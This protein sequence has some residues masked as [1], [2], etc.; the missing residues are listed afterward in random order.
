MDTQRLCS[1]NNVYSWFLETGFC[2]FDGYRQIKAITIALC[3]YSCHSRLST[4]MSSKCVQINKCDIFASPSFFL[5][6]K[7]LFFFFFSD[8]MRDRG[9]GVC[10]VASIV[11]SG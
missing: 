11:A 9:L 8:N 2:S 4:V 7:N 1:N 6:Y 10:N 3:Q 5:V